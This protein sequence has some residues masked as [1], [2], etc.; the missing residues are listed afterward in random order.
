MIA[1]SAESK[2]VFRN[3]QDSADIDIANL[4]SGEKQLFI[5][6]AHLIFSLEE[7]QPGILVVD[8]PELSLHPAWQR[9]YVS[10]IM[11]LQSNVQIIFATHSPQIIGRYTDKVMKLTP[12]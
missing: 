6:F 8:E 4:S 12:N 11:K 2:V 1:L 9:E 10:K 5:F 3:H 7:S